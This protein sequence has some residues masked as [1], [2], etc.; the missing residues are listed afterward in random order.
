LAPAPPRPRRAG[1]APQQQG[2]APPAKPPR[3]RHTTTRKREKDKGK[4]RRKKKEE[5]E[6]E[7]MGGRRRCLD[8][9]LRVPV[10]PTPSLSL[11]RLLA[12][13]GIPTPSLLIDLC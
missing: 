8:S 11:N 10:P 1:P 3:R 4:G 2:L 7:E 9:L 13:K 12:R 5:E 6:G